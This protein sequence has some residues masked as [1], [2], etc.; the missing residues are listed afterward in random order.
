[1]NNGSRQLNFSYAVNPFRLPERVLEYGY[2]AI[3]NLENYPHK[4]YEQ[5]K[6][7]ISE[8]F[9]IDSENIL[10]GNGSNELFNMIVLAIKPKKAMVFL[11]M[12]R[13]FEKALLIEKTDIVYYNLNED[14]NFK[15]DEKFLLDFYSFDGIDIV[16]LTNPYNPVG[17]ILDENI[18]YKFIKICEKKNI[19]LVID[20][21]FS[22]FSKKF[23]ECNLKSDK[24]IIIKSFSKFFKLAG[25]RIAFANISNKI[26]CDKIKMLT[27]EYN[28]S[29]VAEAMVM[30]ILDEDEF[31]DNSRNY[32][33]DEVKYI[34]NAFKNLGIKYFP[35]ETN[36]IMFKEHFELYDYLYSRNIRI[37]ECSNFFNDYEEK[38]YRYYKIYV[39]S[40]FYNVSLV[41]EIY[42]FKKNRKDK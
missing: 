29:I 42:N 31:I 39:Q 26:L 11:P 5:L 22:G 19:Y 4:S 9:C 2:N 7:K 17:Y 32:V 23:K 13:G 15:I 35:T 24:L 21:E 38:E 16:F 36:F 8:K 6:M 28:I 12:F 30:N 40:H 1:M 27:P 18:L 20:E 41:D 33:I 34:E 10:L 14:N 3:N 25:L 37:L